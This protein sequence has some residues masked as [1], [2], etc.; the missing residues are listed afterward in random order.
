[1][2]FPLFVALLLA[3]LQKPDSIVIAPGATLQKLGGGFGFTEGSVDDP[4]GDVYFTDQPNDRI[5]R[6]NTDGT[7][8]EWLKPAGRANG[9]WFDKQGNLYR[10]RR[11]QER[12]MVDLAR[13]PTH[14]FDQGP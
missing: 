5:M 4:K 8:T 10:L 7:I 9:E 3:P 2:L 11:R 14:R 6:W 1:M 13:R 12:T